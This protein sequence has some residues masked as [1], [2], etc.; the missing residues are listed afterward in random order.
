MD[1]KKEYHENPRING[2][3]AALSFT[4]NEIDPVTGETVITRTYCIGDG[5]KTKVVERIPPAV[6]PVAPADAKA[7]EKPK[8]SKYP[9]KVAAKTK[10]ASLKGRSLEPGMVVVYETKEGLEAGV[11]VKVMFRTVCIDIDGTKDKSVKKS[12][13]LGTLAGS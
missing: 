13:V 5:T 11:V 10:I 9:C 4:E 2:K 7:P 6:K 8:A 12:E 1:L 3:P